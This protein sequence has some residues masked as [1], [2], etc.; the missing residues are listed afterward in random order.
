MSTIEST[1]QVLDQP[2][3]PFTL[4]EDQLAA[5][6]FLARYRVRTLE[7]YRHDLRCLFH[8]A[9]DHGLAVLAAGRAHELYRA[10]MEERG[11]AASI[12]D[13]R[14][15]TACGF[16]RFAHIDGLIPPNP[17]HI[18]AAPR[19]TRVRGGAWIAASWPASSHRGALRSHSR[20]LGRA[21]GP[22]RPAGLGGLR[23]QHQ[24]HRHGARPPGAAYCREGP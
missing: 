18:S 3:V 8:W 6:A 21:A 24:G 11:L 17:A 7:V 22:E 1:G 5:V 23:R 15:S 10:W 12:I 2:G 19:S 4:S 20:R 16:Y 9:A 13:R 14:P